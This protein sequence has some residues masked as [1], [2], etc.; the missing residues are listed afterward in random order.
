M[1]DKLNSFWRRWS[2]HLIWWLR[3]PVEVK[4]KQL[5]N[6]SPRIQP[7]MVDKARPILR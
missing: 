5:H 1:I 2:R 6:P 4:V 7:Y 3:S